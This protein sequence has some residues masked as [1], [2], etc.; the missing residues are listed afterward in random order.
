MRLVD[1]VVSVEAGRSAVC[2]RTTRATDFY[3][4]GHFP[5]EPVVPAVVLIELIAQTGGLAA[6][7]PRAG[8]AGQP[9]A[10]RVAAVD[11]FKFPA[12]CG[13][14]VVLEVTARVVGQMGALYKIE[15]VVTAAGV[16]VA[17][18]G[19]TLAAVR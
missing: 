12:G 9:L 8:E 18:G 10:L 11:G 16:L 6:G 13:A 15:G 17:R 3:F 4:D 14:D 1:E 7:A 2:R 5:G 19:V